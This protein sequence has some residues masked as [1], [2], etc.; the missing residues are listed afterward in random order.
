MKIVA[1]I[2]K[3]QFVEKLARK[4]HV[5]PE[6]VEEVF[7]N[8]PRIELVECGNV[9]GENVYWAL[10]RTDAGR[11]LTVFFID[12]HGGRAMPISAR[13]MNAKERRRYAKK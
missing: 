3:P 7:Q 8:R 6:E 11:Y 9:S 10:G 1:F 12:K 13:D 5:S 2:W 4:H